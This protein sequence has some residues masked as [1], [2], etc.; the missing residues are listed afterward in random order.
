MRKI[1]TTSVNKRANILHLVA[2]TL[3]AAA[4]LGA[5]TLA[6]LAFDNNLVPRLS[7]PRLDR[8]ISLCITLHNKTPPHVLW[9][10]N[11]RTI[12]DKTFSAAFLELFSK[13]QDLI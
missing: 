2:G 9:S 7:P 13:G 4:S 1:A 5:F 6:G 10:I 12:Y 3:K 8:E 11:R